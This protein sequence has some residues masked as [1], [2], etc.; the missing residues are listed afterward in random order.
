MSAYDGSNAN[1]GVGSDIATKDGTSL[2]DLSVY[3]VAFKDGNIIDVMPKQRRKR[4]RKVKPPKVDP[5]PA[6]TL[7][8]QNYLAKL[9]TIP[10]K[11]FCD[12]KNAR[13]IHVQDNWQ[14]LTWG[15]CYTKTRKV[16]FCRYGNQC[17]YSHPC[18]EKVDEEYKYTEQELNRLEIR[19]K[20]R[21]TDY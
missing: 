16:P 13:L 18:P 21:V 10:C 15:N 7:I 2:D 9:K 14:S 12:S 6:K 20:I 5:N 17:H 19:R 3:P 8:I 4:V 1:D 11:Y